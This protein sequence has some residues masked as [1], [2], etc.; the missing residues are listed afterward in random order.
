[1]RE[2]RAVRSSPTAPLRSRMVDGRVLQAP[3]NAALRPSPLAIART[4]AAEAVT[5]AGRMI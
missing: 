3:L 5:N 4:A 1:M 2:I